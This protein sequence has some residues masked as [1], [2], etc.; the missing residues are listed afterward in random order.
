MCKWR[1]DVDGTKNRG[2]QKLIQKAVSGFVIAACLAGGLQIKQQIYAADITNPAAKTEVTVGVT[3]RVNDV[4]IEV[5][6]YVTVGLTRDEDGTERLNHVVNPEGYYI[7]NRSWKNRDLIISDIEVVPFTTV[8]VNHPNHW[9]LS[10]W[11]IVKEVDDTLAT[12]D[13]GIRQISLNIGGVQIPTLDRGTENAPAAKKSIWND[14]VTGQKSQFYDPAATGVDCYQIIGQDNATDH[15]IAGPGTTAYTIEANVPRNYLPDDSTAI[16]NNP[17][18]AGIMR[19]QY[20]FSV[21]MDDG[22]GNKKI[23]KVGDLASEE[24]YTGPTPNP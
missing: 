13:P 17:N 2:K 9:V 7:E 6:L 3:E 1:R 12:A 15:N 16:G 14:A 21:V 24:D 8:D 11:Q 4:S 19:I 23:V 10:D 20:T 22:K 5:P 18:T